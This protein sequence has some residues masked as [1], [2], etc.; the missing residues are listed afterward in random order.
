MS[1]GANGNEVK[2]EQPDSSLEACLKEKENE[3]VGEGSPKWTVERKM[4]TASSV[5]VTRFD[6][7][8]S[9]IPA[10]HIANFAL[11]C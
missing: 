6:P 10:I 1:H 11:A 9:L 7:M 2:K 5:A 3:C 8:H 4:V